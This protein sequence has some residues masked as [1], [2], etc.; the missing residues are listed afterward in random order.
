MWRAGE[1]AKPD[2]VTGDSKWHCD[3]QQSYS[4]FLTNK[5]NADIQLERN[6]TNSHLN[7][8]FEPAE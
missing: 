4:T 6:N 8:K 7:A 2:A 3:I 1:V 5:H